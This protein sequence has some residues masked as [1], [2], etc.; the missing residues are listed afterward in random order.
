MFDTVIVKKDDPVKCPKCRGDL[1]NFQTKALENLLD[2]YT[3]GRSSRRVCKYREVKSK[4]EF[5][6]I[7]VQ[8]GLDSALYEKSN[9]LPLMVPDDNTWTVVP[10]PKYHRFTAYDFCKPCEAIVLQ[11]FQFDAK[12]KLSRYGKPRVE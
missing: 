11:D 9:A 8:E 4:S 12:G 10:H 6:R 5:R 1:G 7:C 2:E 3:E